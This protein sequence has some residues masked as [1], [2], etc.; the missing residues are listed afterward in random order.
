MQGGDRR[1]RT[2]ESVVDDAEGMEING[3]KCVFW[4]WVAALVVDERWSIV[5]VLGDGNSVV[6]CKQEPRRKQE[7]EWECEW[8]QWASHQIIRGIQSFIRRA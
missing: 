3:M 7:K 2:A 5:A 6:P 1:R 4:S 8:R